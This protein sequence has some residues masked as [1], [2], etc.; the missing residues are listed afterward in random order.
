MCIHAYIIYI[1]IYTYTY[2]HVLY[3]YIYM[4]YHI[5]VGMGLS[6][7]FMIVSGNIPKSQFPQPTQP[8]HAS[9]TEFVEGPVKNYRDPG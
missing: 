1:Y 6:D 4:I 3:V 5:Y 9:I 8:R 2:M 7:N